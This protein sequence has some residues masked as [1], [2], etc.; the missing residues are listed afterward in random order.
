LA[1]DRTEQFE[2]EE[3]RVLA[4]RECIRITIYQW[5]SR[6]LF[7]KHKMIFM[8]FL[9]FRLMQ[10]KIQLA[11]TIEYSDKE[12][13]FL[14][15]CPMNPSVPKPDSIKDWMPDSAWY[16]MQKLIELEGFEGLANAVEK[17]LPKKFEDWYNEL[18]PE[19]ERL[20]GDYRKFDQM[21]FQ[22]LLVVRCLRP[23]RMPT[24]LGN[25]I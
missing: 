5:V 1:I 6:G 15:N 21:P 2:A 7:E 19:E 12:M 25:F 17:E 11:Q 14:L 8:A 10:K 16:S 24:A 22:K 3:D 23:D 13:H 18:S 20:P 4:L 9:T